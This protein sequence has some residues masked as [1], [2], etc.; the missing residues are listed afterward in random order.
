MDV[1]RIRDKLEDMF[2]NFEPHDRNGRRYFAAKLG[3]MQFAFFRAGDREL[4]FGATQ[5]KS[6]PSSIALTLLRPKSHTAPRWMQP[7]RATLALPASAR[8]QNSS[9]RLLPLDAGQKQPPELA[10]ALGTASGDGEFRIDPRPS[11]SH[12]GVSSTAAWI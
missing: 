12:T 4:V 3:E 7:P 2:G 5:P 6:K 10:R 1:K 11:P 9:L 8:R